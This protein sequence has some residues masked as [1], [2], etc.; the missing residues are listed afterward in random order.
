[1]SGPGETWDGYTKQRAPAEDRKPVSAEFSANWPP[2]TP[3]IAA[4]PK[5]VPG[6][7][8]QQ[9]RR[10]LIHPGEDQGKKSKRRRPAKKQK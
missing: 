1:M 3:G 2:G 5:R 7:G 4:A 8:Q 9:P 10:S 6:G